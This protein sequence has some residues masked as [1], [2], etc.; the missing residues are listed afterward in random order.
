M[1][2]I[3][4]GAGGYSQVDSRSAFSSQQSARAIRRRF[5]L[6]SADQKASREA[7][8]KTRIIFRAFIVFIFL[9]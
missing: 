5:A 9:A 3:K 2:G 8:R 6:I 1:H 7:T 4:R